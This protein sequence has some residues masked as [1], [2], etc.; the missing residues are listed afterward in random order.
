MIRLAAT[1]LATLLVAGAC[2]F[3]S[4]TFSVSDAAVDPSYS[5]P[6]AA[7]NAR[8]Y[9]H[10]T[11]D[12]HNRTSNAVT[13]KSVHATMTLAAVQGAWL[14]KVGDKYDAGEVLFAPS[15]V[16]AG[17]NATMNVS[18]PSACTHGQGAT[19]TS[20]GEYEVAFEIATSAGTFDLTSKTKHRILA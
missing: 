9:V 3:G 11:I 15:S 5:C 6:A 17:S 4:S 20:Y 7:A 1:S 8:Y 18:I 14:Q 19:G 2:S 12:A 13:I 10:A 16:S